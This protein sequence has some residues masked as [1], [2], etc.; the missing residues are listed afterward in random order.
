M[1]EKKITASPFGQWIK[2]EFEARQARPAANDFEKGHL[3]A[4]LALYYLIGESAF[5]S[6]SQHMAARLSQGRALK[7][8]QTDG[9]AWFRAE[10]E[11]ASHKTDLTEYEQGYLQTILG[12]Y[13]A[14]EPARPDPEL[15]KLADRFMADPVMAKLAERFDME[16]RTLQPQYPG[17]P[18][19]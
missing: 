2:R 17:L 5:D 13:F 14:T 6:Q 1:V 9:F 16:T 15:Q 18:N 19:N 11:Q 10:L 8:A 3:D 4:M 12:A 7:P